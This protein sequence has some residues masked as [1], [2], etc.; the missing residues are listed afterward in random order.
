[1]RVLPRSFL[2]CDILR[3]LSQFIRHNTMKAANLVSSLK[4]V[5]FRA[6]FLA[7]KYITSTK[8][9]VPAKSRQKAGEENRK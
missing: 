6:C 9:N 1:M 4:T 7:E 2:R 5:F 3:I 8:R